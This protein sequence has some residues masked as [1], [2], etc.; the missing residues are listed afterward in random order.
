MKIKLSQTDT[1]TSLLCLTGII[2]GIMF[3]G[4]LPERLP[5]HFDINDQP[6]HYAYKAIVVFGIPVLMCIIQIICCAYA[7]DREGEKVPKKA[8]QISRFIIPVLTVL[9]EFL[10]ITFVMDC[11]IKV[12]TTITFFLSLMLIILG[13]YMPKCRRNSTFGIKTPS[14]LK[15]DHVWYKTHRLAGKLSIIAGLA[16]ILLSLAEMLIPAVAVLLSAVLIPS[17]YSFV[18]ADNENR[19]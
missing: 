9:S 19:S 11:R 18:I 12:G 6:D 8:R 4:R 14:T 10:I 3:Y 5:I 15:S 2:P 7:Y 17:A 13:N 1:F 16:A